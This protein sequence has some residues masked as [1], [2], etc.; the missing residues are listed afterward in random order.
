MF[1][2]KDLESELCV[3]DDRALSYLELEKDPVF[4]HLSPEQHLFYLDYAL[5]AGCAQAALYQG[6]DAF[7]LAKKFGVKVVFQPN[8]S[9]IASGTLRATYDAQ[10]ETIEIFASSIAQME[11]SLAPWLD[12]P[13]DTKKIAAIH[14]A[15][16]LFHHLE[17]TQIEPVARQLPPV[18]TLRLGRI[19][20]AQSRVRRC[21]EIAAHAFAKELLELPVLPNIADWL[22]AISR[23]EC[24]LGEFQIALQ[25]AQDEMNAVMPQDLL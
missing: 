12:I 2:L 13:W 8:G 3:P 23:Q 22:L 11:R 4:S 1:S 21:R 20:L 7:A 15:H 5:Q 10:E 16:E 17:A 9:D 19:K 18:T 25:R 14:L 6:A 24:T